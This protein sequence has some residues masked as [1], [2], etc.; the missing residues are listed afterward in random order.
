MADRS[1]SIVVGSNGAPGSVEGCLEALSGQIDGAEVIVCE[2]DASTEDV[3]AHFPFARFLERPDALVPDLWRDG[4]DAATGDDVALTISPMR[5]AADWVAQVRSLLA[6]DQVVAGAIDPGEGL[7]VVDWAEY[8]CRYARDMRP[9][10]RRENPEIPGDNCAYR[11]ELLVR[12]RDVYRDGFWE[13]EVN[14]ALRADGVA[15][16][17]DPALVVYQGRSG[18][19]AAFFRQRLEHG[20]AYGRQRATRFALGRT[21]LGI[22][23]AV[24]VPFL[25]AVRTAREVFSR[26]RFRRQFLVALPLLFVF[27]VA[28]SIGEARGHLDVLRGR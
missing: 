12:T 11:R 25:L 5:P 8:F 26:G 4:I 22:E 20:R 18:G 16:W 19:F 1:L 17:H 15:L 7:R 27:D 13:P 6:A 14:R 24:L 3:K 2:A 28:W 23:L 10:S 9:F 21:M